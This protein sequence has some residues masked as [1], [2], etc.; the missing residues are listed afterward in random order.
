MG[1]PRKRHKL[2]TSLPTLLGILFVFLLSIWFQSKLDPKQRFLQAPSKLGPAKLAMAPSCQVRARHLLSSLLQEAQHLFPW[3]HGAH[4]L[5]SQDPVLLGAAGSR[6]FIMHLRPPEAP[7]LRCSGRTLQN[8]AVI[9]LS[10][11][12]D[13]VDAP[14]SQ[15]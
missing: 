14:F 7:H 10:S 15:T 11:M 3:E 2:L 1:Q 12:L 6:I 4:S 5:G 13:W 8:P 9:P